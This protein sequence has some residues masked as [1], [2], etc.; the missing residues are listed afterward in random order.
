MSALITIADIGTQLRHVRFGSKVDIARCQANVRFTPKK[1]DIRV[2][3]SS[4]S[5]AAL[6]A[7]VVL[8]FAAGR[9]VRHPSRSSIGAVFGPRIEGNGGTR[10]APMD[11]VDNSLEYLKTLRR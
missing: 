1:A 3:P 4:G 11:R 7:N 10:S 6:A 2:W 5:F 9:V 8:L